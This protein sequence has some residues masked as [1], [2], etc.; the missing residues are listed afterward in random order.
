MI[1]AS[2]R[3]GV[4][5]SEL[6]VYLIHPASM[7]HVSVTERLLLIAVISLVAVYWF[8]W[9]AR[10]ETDSTTS[11]AL[12]VKRLRPLEVKEH[13]PRP[14]TPPCSFQTFHAI[15]HQRADGYVP[16]S[17][18]WTRNGTQI[19]RFQ[20]SICRLTHGQWIPEDE[21]ATCLR[22]DRVRYVAIVA[23]SNGRGYLY[24]LRRL[25]SQAPRTTAQRQRIS[26]GPIYRYIRLEYNS[27]RHPQVLVK[28]RCPC[29]GYCTLEFSDDTRDVHC[30]VQQ[31]RCTVDDDTDV[32]LEYITAWFTI[33][34]KVQVPYDPRSQHA[35]C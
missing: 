26:C 4:D 28:H 17:G 12:V 16:G 27:Y 32:L 15:A 35:T 23:D 33:D 8:Y 20:P 22:R 29:G 25:L 18:T 30:D 34:P 2:A 3:F 13:L 10:R 31:V 19:E 5:F 21:L 24:N 11:T 14:V 6:L 7:L 1:A 9:A